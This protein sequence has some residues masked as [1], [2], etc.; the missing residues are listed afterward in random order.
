[1]ENLPHDATSPVLA[2]EQRAVMA[3]LGQLRLADVTALSAV[4][5]D[6]NRGQ[7]GQMLAR[8][9]ASVRAC[10]ESITHRYLVHATPR[11]RLG[12]ALETPDE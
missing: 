8:L 5:A 4:D 7:L 2:A 3:A 6:G 9:D 1:M 11:R 10:D 12:E